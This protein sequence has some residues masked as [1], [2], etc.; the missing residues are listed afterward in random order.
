M[1]TKPEQC[2]QF[3]RADPSRRTVLITGAALSVSALPIASSI[4]LAQNSNRAETAILTI[5]R[6]REAAIQL[7]KAAQASW[8]QMRNRSGL[9]IQILDDLQLDVTAAIQ[10]K[11]GELARRLSQRIQMDFSAGRTVNLD[12]WVLSLA[13]VRFYALAAFR[14]PLE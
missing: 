7:G 9:L 1:T 14:Q 12:G 8:P 3:S 13:E 10:A 5:V 4:G 6:H 2:P 11:T